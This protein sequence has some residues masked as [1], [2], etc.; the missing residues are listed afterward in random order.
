MVPFCVPKPK[1]GKQKV[2][3]FG[4]ELEDTMKDPNLEAPIIVIRCMESVERRGLDAEGIYRVSASLLDINKLKQA[5]DDGET[6]LF[7]HN[8]VSTYFLLSL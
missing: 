6:F 8:V 2:P 1:K 5:F 7:I 3:M 4:S